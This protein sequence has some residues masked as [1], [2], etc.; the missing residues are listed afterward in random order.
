MSVFFMGQYRRRHGLPPRFRSRLLLRGQSLHDT[1]KLDPEADDPWRSWLT[2]EHRT[3]N[4][5]CSKQEA[6]AVGMF[7]FV[8]IYIRCIHT[9]VYI[10][11]CEYSMVICVYIFYIVCNE[12]VHISIHTYAS[13]YIYIYICMYVFEYTDMFVYIRVL[14]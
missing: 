5:G 11:L 3:V 13:I 7:V 1:F 10:Y 14:G 4:G 9:Y 8:Y 6:L 2:W 12:N